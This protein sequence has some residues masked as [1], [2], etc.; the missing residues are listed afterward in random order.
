MQELGVSLGCGA[1]DL[2]AGGHDVSAFPP[3]EVTLFCVML[4]VSGRQARKCSFFHLASG[5]G[6][7][8]LSTEKQSTEILSTESKAF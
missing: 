8:L 2:A 5:T 7:G 3:M 6:E 4:L 1:G